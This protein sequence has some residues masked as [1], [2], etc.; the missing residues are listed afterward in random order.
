M[1]RDCDCT[2][3]LAAGDRRAGDELELAPELDNAGADGLAADAVEVVVEVAVAAVVVAG[4]ALAESAMARS[5]EP[6]S[7][8]CL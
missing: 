2:M 3:C 1:S 5:G 4:A 7:T 6:D 8:Y